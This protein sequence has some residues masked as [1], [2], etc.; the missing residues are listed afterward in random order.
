MVGCKVDGGGLLQFSLSN[1]SEHSACL[2]ELRYMLQLPACCRRKR[3]YCLEPVQPKRQKGYSSGVVKIRSM[4]LT[5]PASV[6]NMPKSLSN[7][8]QNQ[9]TSTLHS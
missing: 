4:R 9:H 8:R 5:L 6:R 3:R 2:W 1:C 7:L